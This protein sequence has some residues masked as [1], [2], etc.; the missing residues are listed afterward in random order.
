MS[1]DPRSQSSENGRAEALAGKAPADGCGRRAGPA[2]GSRRIGCRG[3]RVDQVDAVVASDRRVARARVCVK[4]SDREGGDAA[5]ADLL[6]GQPADLGR[7][8]G[9]CAHL[10]RFVDRPAQED[11]R[12]HPAHDVQVDARQPNRLDREPSLLGDLS[13][14]PIRNV[15]PVFKHTAR[16]LPAPVIPT[17]NAEDPTVLPSNHSSNAD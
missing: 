14:K 4:H 15:L 9:L 11:Q 13:A 7:L 3:C 5:G 2:D 16:D 10:V 1:R 6:H 8:V 12:D 17:P